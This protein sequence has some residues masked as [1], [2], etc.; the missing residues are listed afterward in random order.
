MTIMLTTFMPCSAKLT[1]IA[2]ISGTFFPHNSWVAPSAYFL[3]MMAVVG[4]GIFLKKTKVFAGAPS[5]FVMELPA[6]HFPKLSNTLQSVWYRAQ[7]FIMK[8]GTIIFMSCVAIW[9]LESFNFK[10]QMVDQ[11][12]S[13][14]QALGSFIA[15]IFAPLG[16]GDWHAT[17]A[18][19]AGLIAKENCVGTL[20][21]TFGGSNADFVSSLRAAY[22]PMAGYAFLAFNLLCAPCFASIGTM[23]KEFGDV[24]WTLRAVGYQTLVAYMVATIIYQGSQLMTAHFSLVGLTVAVL[25]LGLMVY[26]LF[27]KRE[28][29]DLGV[30]VSA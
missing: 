28:S 13:I 24:G 22:S 7:A 25:A 6:Y 2:L 16:F 23:Y 29:Q 27:V 3:G 9:F 19:L 12:H 18:V 11:N 5:P 15:P 8:A 1:V 30:K 21:I 26:G 10:L 4:S 17:V 14:L 20:H